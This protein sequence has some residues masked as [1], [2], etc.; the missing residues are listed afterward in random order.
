M[1]GTYGWNGESR[2]SSSPRHTHTWAARSTHLAHSPISA[3]VRKGRDCRSPM[4]CTCDSSRGGA[5][6]QGPGRTCMGAGARA[7]SPGL[8]LCPRASPR[9][10]A[11]QAKKLWLRATCSCLLRDHAQEGLLIWRLA[12]K[13]PRRR[14]MAGSKRRGARGRA[15]KAMRHIVKSP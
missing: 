14:G 12:K 11:R 8:T 13:P 15:E 7:A 5:Y 3:L 4:P 6:Q 1:P 2:F 9:N 10:A